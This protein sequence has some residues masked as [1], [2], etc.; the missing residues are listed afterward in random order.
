MP[1]DFQIAA[2]RAR[3]RVGEHIWST[4]SASMQAIAIYEELRAL[5]L[6]RVAECEGLEQSPG[7]IDG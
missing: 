2:E 1:D 6:R 3:N 4:M 5:D 7:V